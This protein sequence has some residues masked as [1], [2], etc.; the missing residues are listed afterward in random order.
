M[1]DCVSRTGSMML[2]VRGRKCGHSGFSLPWENSTAS[3]SGLAIASAI[4]VNGKAIRRDILSTL[5]RKRLTV[6]FELAEI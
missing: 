1:R 2:I 6:R 4:C 3:S 5:P